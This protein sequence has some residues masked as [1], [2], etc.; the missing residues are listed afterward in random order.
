MDNL[1]T[2]RNLELLPTVTAIRFGQLDESSGQFKDGDLSPDL[3]F[4]LKYGV[5]PNLTADFTINPDFSQIE[6][7]RPQIEINQRFP[8]F[9][10]ELRPFFLEGQEIFS[11]PGSLNLVH[12]RTIVDPRVGGKLTGK[13][14]RTT[15]GVLFADDEA[16]GKRV[17][18]SDPVF[19]RTAQVL[20]GRARYDLYAESHVGAILTDREFVNSY[21]R[22][23]GVDGRF[24]LGRSHGVEF[25]AVT[26]A[27]RDDAGVES[28]GPAL[29]VNFS[30][31]SRRLDYGVRY[32]RIDPEFDTAAGFVRRVDIRR[33]DAH[34]SYRWWPEAAVIS[35]GPNFA[36]GRNI[37]HAGV[38][39]DEDY[40]A[41]WSTRFARNSSA[42]VGA[43]RQLERFQGIDFTKTRF[44]AN[45]SLGMSRRYSVSAG[46]NW[47]DEI[48]FVD[49]PFLGR[50]VGYS[51][52]LTM[53]PTSRLQLTLAL[54]TTTFTDT[55]NET[56]AFDVQIW[57]SFATYQ[58]TDRLLV[59]SI[60]EYNTFQ[61]TFGTNLL[62]TYRV[63]AGTVFFIGYDDHLEEGL[64]L[65]A[66]RFQTR[67]LVRTN[68][69]FFTKFQY[70][71][72]Y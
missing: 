60:N 1:S 46:A 18:G 35:W 11:T 62:F 48:R 54:D 40:R 34:A 3:G 49:N 8:L 16:P 14:G 27:N 24:R 61:G 30:R 5:T 45:G 9:F 38:L 41:E 52:Q 7:D 2:S 65:D 51:V 68:R 10:P 19:D 56:E 69:A 43:M 58:F 70:L 42:R 4:N 31:D 26:S 37:D 36:Y 50:T 64:E 66:E 13:V 20:I 33:T 71:F 25:A 67:L 21:S 12:T 55:R 17:E 28:S 57:R 15:L 39:Q 47:G 72:R 6:T 53:L 29:H 32:N 44:S 59:R 63:N 23:A 22:V